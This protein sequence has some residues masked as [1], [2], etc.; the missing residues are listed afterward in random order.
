MKTVYRVIPKE[1]DELKQWSK[2]FDVSVFLLGRQISAYI[3]VKT[4]DRGSRVV[5]LGAAN[6][7]VQMIQH[8][9]E[10]A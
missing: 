4:D 10:Q 2:P 1:S 6:G 3:V 8:L 7:D 5:D 9:L